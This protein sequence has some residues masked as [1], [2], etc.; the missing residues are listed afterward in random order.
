M[1]EEEQGGM[2]VDRS[3]WQP[4]E[5][6][7]Q[8]LELLVEHLPDII[9]RF[10]PGL[11]CTYTSPAGLR[12]T[13]M[14]LE[15][16]LGKTHHEMG[17]PPEF[18]DHADAALRRVFETGLK[19]SIEFDLPSPEGA[20]HYEAYA[21]PELIRDGRVETV[22]TVSR[23]ITEQRRA[24]DQV[25]TLADAIP[26]LVWMAEPDGN[27]FWYNRRWYEYTGTTSAEME[28]WGWQ[29]VHDPDVLPGVIKRWSESLAT[30]EAF[31]MEFPLR[32]AD[33]SYRSFLTRVTPLKDGGGRV[34]RW[35]G[36]NTDVEELRHTLRQAEESNRL[37]D[38]FLATLSHELRTPM[39]AIVGWTR[40]LRTSNFDETARARALETVERNA[41]AQTRL[42]DDLLDVSS[43]VT[44]N[45]RLD[46]RPVDLG[47]VVAA[48]ADAVR[49]AAAAKGITLQVLIE[50]ETGLASGDPARLQQ[51]VWNLLTNAVKFTPSNGRV[52][53]RLTH[54]GA[55]AEITV[56]DSGVG[57][58]ADFLPHVFDRFRQADQKITRAHG[59]LGLG[60]AIVRQ[61]VE[62]HGGTVIA[63]SQG[64]G[65]GATFVVGL[66]LPP[67]RAGR[68]ANWRR[69][70]LASAG[71]E[72]QQ[73]MSRPQELEGLR[74]LVVDDEPDTRELLVNVLGAC[75][76]RVTAVASATEALEQIARETPDVLVSD[77]GMPEEDGYALIRKI[78]QLPPGRGGRVPA[79]AL[80]AYARAEDRVRVLRSGFQAHV[81]KPVEP[82]ELIAVIANL[83]GRIGDA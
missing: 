47:P 23:D 17:L 74:V 50:P 41:R 21:V 14:P 26:Q 82:E 4:Q 67:V 27:I 35:F 71:E 52:E 30:G 33:G 24:E 57:I 51:V 43:V 59:G 79:A 66:P 9:S 10:D 76:S 8:M 53:V 31:E 29:S 15:A 56:S 69:S 62:L 12:A 5:P 45:L 34:L 63:R 68:G 7:R 40:L 78:R 22:I 11:R 36:T 1:D 61:L 42:I 72:E 19:E 3:G 81:I 28:G 39:T 2:Q 32:G 73:Q 60:L 48:A 58:P 75:G 64:E 6:G 44:G 70:P 80:T 20:R 13:G 65:C 54:A 77:I 37:K 46:V 83:A 55:H 38:E 18:C 49:P 16:V 25:R